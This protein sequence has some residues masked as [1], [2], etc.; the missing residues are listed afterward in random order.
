MPDLT[1]TAPP[2]YPGSLLKSGTFD[3]PDVKH[4]QARLNV[5]LKSGLLEDG[6]F[7]EATENAVRL[8]QARYADPTTGA[9]IDVDG[10]VGAE[11]WA[12][13]FGAETIAPPPP[14]VADGLRAAVLTIARGQIGVLENP[15]GSNRGPQVDTYHR[16]AGLDPA[17][18]NYAWCVSFLQWV[19]AQAF[20]SSPLFRTAG[21]HVLWAKRMVGST[22]VVTANKASRHTVKPGMVFVLDTGGGK[23]HVGLVEAVNGSKGTL[24]TIEGNTNNGGSREGVGVFQRHS[25]KINMSGLLGY[26]DY[27]P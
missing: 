18:G 11:T 4:V 8:F 22:A 9:A 16:A 17:A 6:D 21:V 10:K 23:G 2:P 7:G 14:P 26:I 13:L 12:A 5:L 20:Q 25:R 19:F 15:L 3:S 24:V 1:D 27:C